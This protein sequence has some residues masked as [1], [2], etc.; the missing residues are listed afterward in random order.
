MT[1]YVM[2]K[3]KIKTHLSC[4][5]SFLL[6]PPIDLSV[7][8][9]EVVSTVLP[10]VIITKKKHTQRFVRHRKFVRQHTVQSVARAQRMAFAYG[11]DGAMND[12]R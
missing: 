5:F 9:I 12:D 10:W 8:K 6:L 2:K 3:K 11:F 1:E 7:R 4:S